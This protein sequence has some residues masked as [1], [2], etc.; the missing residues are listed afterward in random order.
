[1]ELLRG[2]PWYTRGVI[3]DFHPALLDE[4]ARVDDLLEGLDRMLDG[5]T[6]IE[7]AVWIVEVGKADTW[8]ELN[9]GIGDRGLRL[10]LDVDLRG[11]RDH[12][13]VA[14]QLGYWLDKG[15]GGFKSD[16]PA[17][18]WNML[19]TEADT[20]CARLG[21]RRVGSRIDESYLELPGL[22]GA[23]ADCTHPGH[24]VA[25]L[26][27]AA[28]EW[29]ARSFREF[30][31]SFEEHL[32]PE[33]WPRYSATGL[34]RARLAGGAAYSRARLLTMMLL[35]LRG[36]PVVPGLTA[37]FER[38]WS[39]KEDRTPGSDINFLRHM[40]ALRSTCPALWAGDY[41][42]LSFE[43]EDVF[44]YVRET[45]L[46]RITVVMNFSARPVEV[47]LLGQ[48]GNWIAG[49]HLVQGDGRLYGGETVSLEGFEGRLYEQRRRLG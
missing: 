21:L 12:E 14:G 6:G 44:G 8:R 32:G 26:D 1:M 27:L 25:G 4:A 43:E 3:F 18:G 29:G 17:N 11:S 9:R 23:F 36:T 40:L 49:T 42:A 13:A 47:K 45:E 19:P 28:L 5:N 7:G 15:A 38:P 37:D 10:L 39:E 41:H 16:V 35:S 22:S 31:G 2:E 33:G 34:E 48:V 20:L 46:Q 30:L 24:R